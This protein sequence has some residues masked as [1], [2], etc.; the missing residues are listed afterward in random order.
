MKNSFLF[1]GPQSNKKKNSVGGIVVLFEDW[2]SQISR[3]NIDYRI[4]DT[5]K[6][7]YNSR[8]GSIISIIYQLWCNV[9]K[10][11]VVMLHGTFKDFI[12]IGP[13]VLLFCKIYKKPYV[14]RKFAGNFKELYDKSSVVKRYLLDRVIQRSKISYWETQHLTNWCKERYKNN[15]VKWFPNVRIRSKLIRNVRPYQKKF[16]FISRVT[17]SKGVDTLIEAFHELGNDYQLSI[18]GSIDGYDI[19]QLSPYYKGCLEPSS[20]TQ[21]LKLNDVLILPTTWVGEGYPGIIIE[22]MSAGVP[23]I[24][25]KVGGIPELIQS[26]SNGILMNGASKEAILEAINQF[27]KYDYGSLSKNALESFNQYDSEIITA[28]VLKELNQL[29]ESN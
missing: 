5:N 21:T 13:F 14:L 11:S 16:V 1:L 15:D 7:N 2:I 19:T 9:D 18:Y 26:G 20:I 6:S 25:T 29:E 22:S 8:I 3:Y 24:A 17:P 28:N 4:I 12:F 23:I 10:C 27:E